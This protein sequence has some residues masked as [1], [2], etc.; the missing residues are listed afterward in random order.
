MVYD[1]AVAESTLEWPSRM[2]VPCPGETADHVIVGGTLDDLADQ[3]DRRLERLGAQADGVR[4][5]RGFAAELG[6]TVERFNGFAAGGVDEDFGR[7][8]SISDINFNPP[9]RAGNEANPTMFSLPLRSLSRD[10]HRSRDDGHQG[11]AEDRP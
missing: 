1:S 10:H 7:G 11:R 4:L 6:R 2:P 3:L 9:A 5:D 8:K